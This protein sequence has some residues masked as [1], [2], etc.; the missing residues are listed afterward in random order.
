MSFKKASHWL[1][2]LLIASFVVSVAAGCAPVSVAESYPLESVNQDGAET[3]YVYRAAGASVP[4]VARLL[5]E[6][7]APKQAS[8]ED[9]ERMFLVYDEEWIHL[10][11]DPEQPSDTL[12]EV[13]SV[14]Y[15]QNNYS[16][17]FLQ[18]FLLATVLDDL[19]DASRRSG[20]YRGY[21]TK[22][23]YKPKTEY[24]APTAEDRKVAP[25]VTVER[26]GSILKRGGG[27]DHTVGSSG[28]ILKRDTDKG[29]IAPDTKDSGAKA[30]PSAF[31]PP[32]KFKAP[33]TKVGGFGKITRRR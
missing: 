17:S 31:Q 26:K 21:S 6:Q 28:N 30:K 19:F 33:K 9:E 20:D 7:R 16:P 32:K 24:R 12:I 25:P 14:A 27:A 22:D 18:G 4:E 29:V 1:K 11:Q 15:V 3:S 10:Q 8:A 13:S 23:T 5:A 2:L